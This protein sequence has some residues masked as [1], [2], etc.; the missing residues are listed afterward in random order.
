M[1]D[2]SL[3]KKI[4]LPLL[5]FYGLGT[6]LGAGI[7][8]LIGEVVLRAQQYT[9][10]AFITSAIIAGITAYS[11]ARLASMHPKSAGEAAYVHA[12]FNSKSVSLFV[13]LCVVMVGSVSAA[14]M[15]RGFSAY[16]TEIYP[17]YDFAVIVGIIVFITS[18]SLWGISQS[19]WLATLITIIEILGLF[20]VIVTVFDSTNPSAVVTSLQAPSS[21]HLPIIMYA[22]F[23]SFYAYIGFED[24]VNIAEETIN[25]RK[26]VPLAILLSLVI[27]TFLYISLAVICTAYIPLQVF[28]NNEAPLV[29][30]IQHKGYNSTLIAVISM[31]A[32]INGALVQMIM[33]SRVLYGM[34]KQNLFFSVFR[35]VNSVTRTPVIATLMVAL[36]ILALSSQF[37][38][39]TLAEITSAITL[40]IFISV[41]AALIFISRRDNSKNYWDLIIPGIGIGL[42]GLLI[43]YGFFITTS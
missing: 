38:L 4:S 14:T 35:Q 25:A 10:L 7:Y 19:I 20:F 39:V 6:I 32:I 11:F 43:L 5:T 28:E 17:V 15:V 33:A 3:A 29:A 36:I 40:V 27:S 31:V 18:F 37:N 9:Y 30:I 2:V 8:V 24:I 34:S 1:S 16:F 13:G 41:Q 12:A 23:I 26:A 22:A 21:N 42:N